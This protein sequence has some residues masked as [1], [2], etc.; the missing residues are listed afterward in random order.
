M[1]TR[2]KRRRAALVHGKVEEKAAEK[3]FVFVLDADFQLVQNK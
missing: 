2:L 3:V 1:W